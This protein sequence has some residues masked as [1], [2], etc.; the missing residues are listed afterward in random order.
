MTFFAEERAVS[1]VLGG[2]LMFGLAASLLILTQ[3]SLVPAANQQVEFEHNLGVQEDFER[4]QGSATR[5]AATGAPESV[6]V[7][8]GVRY[9]NRF[10]LVNPAPSS[11]SLLSEGATITVANVSATNLET[12]E[13]FVSEGNALGYE[14]KRLLYD[15]NYNQYANA[16]RTVHENGV[17]FNEFDGDVTLVTSATP[18]VNDGDITLILLDGDVTEQGTGSAS[19]TLQAASA[20]SQRIAITNTGTDPI[21]ITLDTRLPESE[22]EA[23]NDSATDVTKVQYNGDEVTITL[24]TSRDYTLRVARL[25]IGDSPAPQG[26][27]YVTS[28]GTPVSS[29]P[30][31]SSVT[32]TVELRDEHN[33]P[34]SGVDL[35]AAIDTGATFS[36]VTGPSTTAPALT[37]DEDGRVTVTIVGNDNYEGPATVRIG[38]PDSSNSIDTTNPQTYTESTVSFVPTAVTNVEQVADVGSAINPGLDSGA[39]VFETSALSGSE[40]TMT[41]RYTGTEPTEIT[42]ARVNYYFVASPGVN[43]NPDSL[44]LDTE[45][46]ATRSIEIGGVWQDLSTDTYSLSPGGPLV[47]TG[48]LFDGNSPYT[49]KGTS[50]DFFMLSLEFDDGSTKVYIVPVSK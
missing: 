37:T 28:V 17:T 19:L 10:F 29:T 32:Y 48:Q 23:F 21:T 38:L 46:G 15:P 11:G 14:T 45:S 34:V 24:D 30:S 49:L 43:G 47:V 4:F 9:P 6:D 33:N 16:P 20:P 13:Y 25:S 44:V 18:L 8:L 12:N 41:F 1:P 39:L 2:I 31:Q 40:V 3:V 36:T 35:T 27:A 5:V 26:T 50:D 7:H 42:A 22:W